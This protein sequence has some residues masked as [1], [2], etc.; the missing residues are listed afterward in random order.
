MANFKLAYANF[1]EWNPDQEI[2]EAAS[3]LYYGDVNNLELY[4]QSLQTPPP[5]DI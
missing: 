3:K 5:N 2:A 1:Y 4:G